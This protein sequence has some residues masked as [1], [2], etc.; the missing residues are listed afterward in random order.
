MDYD[1]AYSLLLCDTAGFA[2]RPDAVA[3]LGMSR[4]EE[5]GQDWPLFLGPMV[6]DAISHCVWILDAMADNGLL[7]P[8]VLGMQD[9]RKE[10]VMHLIAR[11]GQLHVLAD[12][13]LL[14]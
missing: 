9:E 8:E 7:T 3:L 10:T 11:R 1:E 12:R 2:A 6:I 4:P 13:D 5:D 14:V